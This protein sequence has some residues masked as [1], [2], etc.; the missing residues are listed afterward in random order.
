[1]ENAA[2]STEKKP[3]TNLTAIHYGA[4]LLL[5]AGIRFFELATSGWYFRVMAYESDMAWWVA[6]VL[7]GIVCFVAT[8]LLRKLFSPAISI[9]MSTV[10]GGAVT[11]VVSSIPGMGVG[12]V[13]GALSAFNISRQFVFVI[14]KAILWL[15]LPAA[16]IGLL[17]G[18]FGG[19]S[20]I[21]VNSPIDI[22]KMS[23]WILLGISIVGCVWVFFLGRKDRRA[24]GANPIADICAFV[25]FFIVCTVAFLFGVEFE[26][27]RRM[28]M[29][30]NVWSS[31]MMPLGYESLV[32]GLK[33]PS[34]L[35]IYDDFP[36]ADGKLLSPFSNFNQ[37]LIRS[38][39]SRYGI[40]D[41]ERT[42]Q[43]DLAGL[44]EID[45]RTV[46]TVHSQALSNGFGDIGLL[47]LQ[48]CGQ[49]VTLTIPG[50]LVTDSGMV[51]LE[52]MQYLT[53]LD[54]S[55][56]NVTAN[57]LAH[58]HPK[59][60]VTFTTLAGCP[61]N[62]EV[63]TILS[64][65]MVEHLNLAGTKVRGDTLKDADFSS[66]NLL[67]VAN[68][69]FDENNLRFLPPKKIRV[70]DLSGTSVSANGL[71]LVTQ[72]TAMNELTLL[73]TNL[74][75]DDVSVLAKCSLNE[76]S[77]DA[78]KLTLKSCK[79][80]AKSSQV[81]LVF[82]FDE[83][84]DASFEEIAKRSSEMRE[85][86][87]RLQGRTLASQIAGRP[88]ITIT[89]DGLRVTKD[90]TPTLRELDCKLT[91]PVVVSSDGKTELK[92]YVNPRDRLMAEIGAQQPK[93]IGTEEINSL[94]ARE[95]QQRRDDRII[96]ART[97]N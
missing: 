19:M 12:L 51:A 33:E 41:E 37:V 81:N 58:L 55:G 3:A 62:D 91:N 32:R 15:G 30:G 83:A 25:A 6:S 26:N 70:L 29:A 36:E 24:K 57:G 7:A 90:M 69:E 78:T 79:A 60:G 73:N 43:L 13:V 4:I 45:L 86:I 89:I 44:N 17:G 16:A 66:L 34:F 94:Y 42:G 54:L 92:T 31:R 59:A 11:L 35:Q 88:A 65:R 50:S 95:E 77:I 28:T 5:L 84:V 21:R 61:V 1:M 93:A 9:L 18:Y 72:L 49:L 56:S 46:T 67:N 53:N 87:V 71:R 82:R 40:P 2:Q 52:N 97:R 64:G 85:E 80:L 68:T 22:F 14:L 20:I 8:I 96:E 74:N 48:Q 75:D 47:G 23:M 63:F 39:Q 76:L 27:Q 10:I 38:Y